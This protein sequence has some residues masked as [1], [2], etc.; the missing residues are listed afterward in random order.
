MEN[1]KAARLIMVTPFN[2]EKKLHEEMVN[3]KKKIKKEFNLY[4]KVLLHD[5]FRFSWT[6]AI[7][8]L[9]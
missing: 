4:L 3:L 7:C 5:G 2:L 1:S 6:V 8:K 9:P